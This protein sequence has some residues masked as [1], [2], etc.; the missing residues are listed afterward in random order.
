MPM[1]TRE[2]S[3]HLGAFELYYAMG[4]ERTHAE[5]AKR[6]NLN[7]GTISNWSAAFSWA[8]RLEERDKLIGKLVANKAIEDE[9]KSRTIQ[10]QVARAVQAKVAQGLLNGTIR[11]DVQ[12][13]VAASKHELLILGKAT[14]RTEQLAGPAFDALIDK[15]AQ[16]IEASVPSKCAACAAE[17]GI[18]AKLSEG[19]AG[20]AAEL[21]GHA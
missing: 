15:I 6:M 12:D 14:E 19:L 9:A 1:P 8:K 20:A 17:L 5:V 16:V 13:F 11:P 4:D 7:V 21:G 18:R 2:S 3:R 10:L